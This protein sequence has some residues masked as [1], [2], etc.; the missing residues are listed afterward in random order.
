MYILTRSSEK[1]KHNLEE[2]STQFTLSYTVYE[3]VKQV[4]NSTFNKFAVTYDALSS[5]VKYQDTMPSLFECIKALS[6]LSFEREN[7]VSPRYILERWSKNVK[8]RNTHIKSSHNKPLSES[9]SRR[10]DNL[11]FWSQIYLSHDD[12]SLEDINELQSPPRMR[13]RRRPKNRLRLNMEKHI[14]NASKKKKKEK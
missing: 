11:V 6:A 14:A 8:R 9:R 12:T 3:V 13:T 7:K 1:S 4:F 2:I 10:F 5:E